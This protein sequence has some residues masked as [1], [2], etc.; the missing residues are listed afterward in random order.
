MKWVALFSQTGSEICN[1]SEALNR[2]PD[3]IITDAQHIQNID[4]RIFSCSSN[5]CLK[6]YPRGKTEHE[7]TQYYIEELEL[8]ED[9]IITLHGW[10]NIVPKNIC[11]AYTIFNGHPGLIDL[12]PEL[13]GRDPQK[14]A[15]DNIHHYEYVGSVIHKVT[16]G[17]DEGEIVMKSQAPSFEC[18][19][20]DNTFNVLRSTSF[21]SWIDFLKPIL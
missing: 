16:P 5:V 19:S 13:K 1:I 17:V 6:K 7:K 12:Y 8:G 15:F 14:R 21:K 9:A 20:L 18:T 3:K 2:K 11:N 10:L 4:S